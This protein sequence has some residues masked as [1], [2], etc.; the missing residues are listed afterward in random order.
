MIA[1]YNSSLQFLALVIGIVCQ[2]GFV[3]MYSRVE[4]HVNYIGRAL[5]AKSGSMLFSLAI[6]FLAGLAVQTLTYRP[7]WEWIIP[8]ITF[9]DWVLAFAI[10]IQWRALWRQQHEG[11]LDAKATQ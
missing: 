6:T 3:M 2:A 9:A 5:M 10:A 11:E 7:G 8:L 1:S 4:W